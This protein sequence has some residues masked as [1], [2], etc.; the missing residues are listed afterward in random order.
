MKIVAEKSN[1]LYLALTDYENAFDC[2]ET[3]AVYKTTPNRR[4]QQL[5][6]SM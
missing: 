1:S 6:K 3:W 4:I 5:D 2:I